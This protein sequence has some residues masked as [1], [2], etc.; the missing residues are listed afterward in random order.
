M[1]SNHSIYF[2]VKIEKTFENDQAK[3]GLSFLFLIQDKNTLSMC[4]L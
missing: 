3:M 2:I 1:E 4:S